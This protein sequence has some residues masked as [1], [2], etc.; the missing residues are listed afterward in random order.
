MSRGDALERR[1]RRARDRDRRVVVVEIFVPAGRVPCAYNAT[2]GAVARV[3]ADAVTA[4][5]SQPSS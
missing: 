4:E 3:S 2:E 5:S 1:H